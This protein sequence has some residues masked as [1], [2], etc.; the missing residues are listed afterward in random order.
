MLV[1]Y[2]I[3]KSEINILIP[4]PKFYFVDL[5]KIGQLGIVLQ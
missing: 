5:I 3:L 4:F 1:Y 2:S